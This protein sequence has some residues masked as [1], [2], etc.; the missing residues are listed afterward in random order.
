MKRLLILGG[1]W[2]VIAAGALLMPVPVPFPAGAMM[3]LIGCAI[4]T[5]HSK[6][7]RR[8]VQYVRHQHAGLSRALET[9]TERAPRRVKTM[10]HHTR[11]LA[12][13]RR[14]RMRAR[15]APDSV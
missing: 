12:L 4:L 9:I 11:P 14:D 3:F 15:R 8:S 7:F 1:G 5:A 6:S 13:G 2:A 10:V